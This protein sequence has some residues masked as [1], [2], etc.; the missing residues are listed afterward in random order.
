MANEN[1]ITQ[2]KNSSK[3]TQ[4]V[5]SRKKKKPRRSGVSSNELK[6]SIYRL[7]LRVPSQLRTPPLALVRFAREISPTRGGSQLRDIL[8]AAAKSTRLS[9]MSALDIHFSILNFV[10][11]NLSHSGLLM[12][13]F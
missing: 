4:N 7:K 10:Y 1:I 12:N 9:T 5:S 8:L 3:K 2:R 6:S 13:D 11:Y